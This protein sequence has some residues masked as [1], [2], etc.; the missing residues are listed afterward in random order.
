VSDILNQDIEQSENR[1]T[2]QNMEI[3]KKTKQSI[4]EEFNEFGT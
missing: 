2:E 1:E 3:V 4:E